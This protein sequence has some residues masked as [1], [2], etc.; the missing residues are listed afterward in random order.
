MENKYSTIYINKEPNLAIFTQTELCY[1]ASIIG[2]SG[3]KCRAN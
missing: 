1:F 2:I 3:T